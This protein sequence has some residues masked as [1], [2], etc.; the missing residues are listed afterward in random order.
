MFPLVLIN[1]NLS[2]VCGI[3]FTAYVANAVSAAFS[4]DTFRHQFESFMLWKNHYGKEYSSIDEEVSRFEIWSQASD[5]VT[6]HNSNNYPWSLSMNEFSDMT[7]DEF[8]SKTN[9]LV[10]PIFEA[11]TAT[12]PVS[13][14]IPALRR[15]F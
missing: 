2:T 6:R 15:C 10:P 13:R 8:K 14:K 4:P 12:F 1:N 11:D 5:K 7:S 3:A 9:G